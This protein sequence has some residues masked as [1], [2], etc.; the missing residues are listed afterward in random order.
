MSFP[1][2]PGDPHYALFSAQTWPSSAQCWFA[3]SASLAPGSSGGHC[4]CCWSSRV[5]AVSQVKARA[6]GLLGLA[7]AGEGAWLLNAWS[8]V[9]GLESQIPADP[10]DGG[11]ECLALWEG[12]GWQVCTP[13]NVHAGRHQKSVSPPCSFQQGTRAQPGPGIPARSLG[14]SRVHS[15]HKLVLTCGHFTQ[16]SHTLSQ[17]WVR[18][19]LET[20]GG[21]RLAVMRKKVRDEEA[22][23]MDRALCRGRQL[24]CVGQGLQARMSWLW[25]G[26]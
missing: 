10:Q 4:G 20:G 18:P 7:G 21:V 9:C 15:V 19:A 2:S 22:G 16:A 17:M 13:R 26:P 1:G 14:G 6:A 25:L 23:D 3:L 8:V 11:L 24:P 12:G 5:P